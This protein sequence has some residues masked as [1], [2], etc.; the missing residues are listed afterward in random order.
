MTPKR[1]DDGAK[2]RCV[3]HNRAMPEGQ[4]LETTVT[5]NVNCEYNFFF[6]VSPPVPRRVQT[7]FAS[8]QFVL[9]ISARHHRN[10]RQN[11]FFSSLFCA[12]IKWTAIVPKPTVSIKMS[13]QRQSAEINWK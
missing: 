7:H 2:Y 3:V 6:R 12:Q 11:T 8:H 1:E 13:T 4:R 5:L 10:E 9:L